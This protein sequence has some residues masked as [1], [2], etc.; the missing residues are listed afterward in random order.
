MH[1]E[2]AYTTVNNTTMIPERTLSAIAREISRD[3]TNV[4]FGAVPYLE[5]MRS[6][7]S[8]NDKYYEDTGRSIVAYFLGNANTWRGPV[9]RRIKLELKALL[10][11]RS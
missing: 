10:K 2:H 7:D 9:A 4:W 1:P 6:L 8:I 11:A 3:W 5:A